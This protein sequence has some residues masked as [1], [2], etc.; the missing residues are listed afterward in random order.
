MSCNWC[1]VWRVFAENPLILAVKRDTYA[2]SHT[3]SGRVSGTRMQQNKSQAEIC[4]FRKLQSRTIFA[5]NHDS[6]SSPLQFASHSSQSFSITYQLRLAGSA[7]SRERKSS[8]SPQGQ[9][10]KRL[11]VVSTNQRSSIYSRRCRRA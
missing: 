9:R 4:S 5:S 7:W 1:L 3:Q 10:H 2:S 11:L 8:T 6:L